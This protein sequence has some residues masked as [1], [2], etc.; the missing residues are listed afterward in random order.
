MNKM[1]KSFFCS[2][3]GLLVTA[4]VLMRVLEH[5]ASISNGRAHVM[6]WNS[7]VIMWQVF[8]VIAAAL[9]IKWFFY[10]MRRTDPIITWF[11][12]KEP[13]KQ[14]GGGKKKGKKK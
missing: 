1:M 9:C 2:L 11:P 12:I 3:N 7:A 14:G 4:Y 13:E 8:L 6:Y 10:I 5:L